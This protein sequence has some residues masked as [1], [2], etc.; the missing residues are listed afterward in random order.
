MKNSSGFS[1]TQS[2]PSSLTVC[3]PVLLLTHDVFF[4][5]ALLW[6]APQDFSH[7]KSLKT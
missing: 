6:R 4:L 2:M 1:E 7:L 5:Q 3:L